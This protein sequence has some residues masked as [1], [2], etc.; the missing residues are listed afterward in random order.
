MCSACCTRR[1]KYR[2]Q[3]ALQTHKNPKTQL[4]FMP[5]TLKSMPGLSRAPAALRGVL[6]SSS[7][8]SKTT[9]NQVPDFFN[10][11]AGR[12]RFVF[13][14]Q[15]CS[16]VFQLGKLL[17][18]ATAS[19]NFPAPA[20]I[21]ESSLGKISQAHFSVKEGRKK[22]SIKLNQGAGRYFNQRHGLY[23][24]SGVQRLPGFFFF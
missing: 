17:S 1:G 19:I 18:H 8:S 24:P 15:R 10:P 9:P 20:T 6:A 23:T 13:P 11:G 4:H 2:I 22:R 16:P 3:N 12:G 14:Q 7:K 21:G 5:K